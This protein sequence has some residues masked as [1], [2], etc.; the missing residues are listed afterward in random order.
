MAVLPDRT[1]NSFK[2]FLIEN[3]NKNSIIKTDGFK[4]YPEAVS[5][6]NCTHL[7]V[8]HSEGFVAPDGTH[9]NLIENLWSHLKTDIKTRRGIMY[10]NL[11]SYIGRM[12][13]YIQ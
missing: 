13:Y 2:R 5:A 7:I 11:S 4:S 9:T 1:V 10:N 3:V 6:A 12:G 8:N